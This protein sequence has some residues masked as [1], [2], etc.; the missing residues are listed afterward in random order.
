MKN[1]ILTVVG[2]FESE[3]MCKQIALSITPIVDSPNLKFQYMGGVL[4]FHFAT[5]VPKDEVYFYVFDALFDITETFILTEITDEVSVSMTLELEKH[6]LDLDNIGDDVTMLLDMNQIKYGQYNSEEEEESFVAL[7]LEEVSQ[8]SKKPALDE[9]L[10]KIYKQGF[11]S[12]SLFEKN[13]LDT[14]SK[15]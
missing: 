9:I 6:L 14:Y 10:E 8:S 12:L 7:L 11:D 3:E 15:T 2:S 13:V 4:L 1:Y 5:E